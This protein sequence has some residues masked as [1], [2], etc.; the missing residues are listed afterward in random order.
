MWRVLPIDNSAREN[1]LFRLTKVG[2][3]HPGK[4]AFPKS[5]ERM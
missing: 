5:L 2:C 3:G 1:N 4:G